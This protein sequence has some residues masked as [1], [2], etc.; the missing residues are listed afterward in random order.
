MGM[1]VH[2]LSSHLDR[3]PENLSDVGQEHGERFHQNIKDMERRYQEQWNAAM[4][5]D[6]CWGLSREEVD[7]QHRRLS[8][9]GHRS[10]QVAT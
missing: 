4:I 10:R 8:K 2:F 1:K 7:K 3:F 9:K 5:F 6:Y